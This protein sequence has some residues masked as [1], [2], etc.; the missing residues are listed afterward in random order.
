M[1]N[2]T[3]SYLREHEIFVARTHSKQD[4][5]VPKAAGFFW[6]PEP[7]RCYGSQRGLDCAAC[8]AGLRLSWWT[9]QR[10]AAAELTQY[11]DPS[12]HEA[13]TEHLRVIEASRATDADIDIPANPGLTYLGYQKA[14]VHFALAR[15]RTLIGDEMGLGKTIQALGY[16]NAKEDIRTVLILCPASLK[17][18]WQ[19]EARKWLVRKF[20]VLIVS[21]THT[22]LMAGGG[23][24]PDRGLVAIVNYEF[25]RDP[26]RRALLMS[27][28]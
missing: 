16:I 10:A 6:H 2:V 19:R 4:G 12:A 17:S 13:L 23:A 7:G 18:N 14:G 8:D 22:A 15:K 9:A 26:I 20:F 25:V 28:E 3:L 5:A 27:T 11:A 24:P 1:P 21:D